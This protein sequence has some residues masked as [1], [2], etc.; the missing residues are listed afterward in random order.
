MV[1]ARRNSSDTDL[2]DLRR[3]LDAEPGDAEARAQLIVRLARVGAWREIADL[4]READLRQRGRTITVIA[5]GG[6]QG[7][8]A[9]HEIE[10]DKRLPPLE[11]PSRIADAVEAWAVNTDRSL[12]DDYSARLAEEIHAAGLRWHEILGLAALKP[13]L[14]AA[15]FRHVG[16]VNPSVTLYGAVNPIEAGRD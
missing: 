15:G 3:R 12:L 16:E 2:R 4:S 1:R 5:L 8:Y 14:A 6:Q 10:H 13:V 9:M 11:V 7:V